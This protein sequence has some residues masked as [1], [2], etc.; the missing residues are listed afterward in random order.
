[1][2]TCDSFHVDPDS[3]FSSSD[4]DNLHKPV[5]LFLWCTF[6]AYYRY[7]ERALIPTAMRRLPPIYDFNDE[8]LIAW[9]LLKTPSRL[10]SISELRCSPS[11]TS[12]TTRKASTHLS[13]LC[14]RHAEVIVIDVHERLPWAFYPYSLPSSSC[15]TALWPPTGQILLVFLYM[16]H[17]NCNGGGRNTPLSSR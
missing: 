4:H 1:M 2:T 10:P 6:I 17:L 14:L 15:L 7:H 11:R 5:W 3:C 9:P 8:H 12:M 13:L 16:I